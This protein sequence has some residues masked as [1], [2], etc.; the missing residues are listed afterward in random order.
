MIVLAEVAASFQ[1]EV[2]KGEAEERGFG[3]PNG[4]HERES[5]ERSSGH[6]W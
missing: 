6:E 2:W 1:A 4:N 3:G 5:W